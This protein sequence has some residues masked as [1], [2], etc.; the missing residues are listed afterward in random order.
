MGVRHPHRRDPAARRLAGILLRPEQLSA[1]EEARRERQ[2]TASLRGIVEYEFSSDGSKLLVPLSGDLY[3]YD[4]KSRSRGAR[5]LTST[6]SYETDA[7]F[8]PRG[9]YVSFIRDQDLFVI[10]LAT[11]VE[12]AITTDGEA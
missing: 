8:S 2:R 1:E 9:R 7:R 5:Q 4:L 10:D 6:E 12:R 3:V 11:G